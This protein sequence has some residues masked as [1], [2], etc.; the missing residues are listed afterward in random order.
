MNG[1]DL[2]LEQADR[3]GCAWLTGG[4][5]KDAEVLREVMAPVWRDANEPPADG[6]ECIVMLHP[7]VVRVGWRFMAPASQDGW[8]DESGHRIFPVKWMPMPGDAA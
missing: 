2:L 1:N 5:A 6:K 4:R 7:G 3:I 8:C